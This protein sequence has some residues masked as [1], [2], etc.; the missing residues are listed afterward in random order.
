MARDTF[1]EREE[2]KDASG[3]RE[4]E[5]RGER[6]GGNVRNTSVFHREEKYANE[7]TSRTDNLDG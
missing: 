7:D 1:H 4:K 3:A 6:G 5:K 2:K